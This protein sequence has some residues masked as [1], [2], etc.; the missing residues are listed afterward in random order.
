[1]PLFRSMLF[2]PADHPRRTEKALSLNCDA[3]ILDLED[4]VAVSEKVASRARAT[5]AL[6]LPRHGRGYIRVN[7]AETEWG[8]GDLVAS[9]LPGVDGI[10]LPKVEAADTLK[11][12]DWVIGALERERDLTPGSIDLIP[13]IETARGITQI[14][15]ITRAVPRARRIAFGAGDFSLDLNLTWSSEESE[16]LP[17]RSSMV[18]HSRAAGLEPP[19]DTVWVDLPNA[20][21]FARSAERGRALGFQ[22]KLCIHPDQIA[23]ANAA[24]SPTTEQ[25]I[26]SRWVVD[27]FTEAE[28]TGSAAIRVDGKFVDY[29]ILHQAQRLL[30]RAAET[31]MA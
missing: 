2:A 24:F 17:F 28:R 14:D 5:A 15:A 1:M 23:M 20:E 3:V 4:A 19:I 6:S 30:D 21:G 13:L 12:V 7:P 29:P 26:R 8:Y 25:V 31:G 10:V 11:A 16:L 22:G 18:A 9:V 27:A